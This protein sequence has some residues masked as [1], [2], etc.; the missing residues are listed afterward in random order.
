MNLCE[1]LSIISSFVSRKVSLTWTF[2][3]MVKPL[4]IAVVPGGHV[5]PPSKQKPF[6]VIPEST[7]G[8]AFRPHDKITSVEELRSGRRWV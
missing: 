8:I 4:L 2:I 3:L 6:L 7:K 5:K 1:P